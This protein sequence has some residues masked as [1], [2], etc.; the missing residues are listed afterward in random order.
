MGSK[1]NVSHDKYPKQGKYLGVR[2]DVTFNYEFDKPIQG[3]MVRDDREEPWETIIK[4]DDGR[5]IRGVECQYNPL[6]IEE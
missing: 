4:L 1:P 3:I 5:Y 6:D 2:V